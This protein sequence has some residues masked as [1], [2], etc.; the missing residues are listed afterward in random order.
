MEEKIKA[1]N[2]DHFASNRQKADPY[3]CETH[4]CSVGETEE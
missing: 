4:D 2:G 3:G 1:E